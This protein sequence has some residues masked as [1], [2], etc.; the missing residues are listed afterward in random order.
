MSQSLKRGML[1][2]LSAN[3]LGLIINVITNF[4]LPKYLAVESY[5]AIKT[6]TLYI[7][8]SGFFHLGYEDGMYLKY[9]GKSKYELDKMDFGLN[10]SSLRIFQLV[11]SLIIFIIAMILNN[12]ILLVFSISLLPYN[13]VMYFRN[14]YQAIGEFNS[15][16]KLMNFMTC[17][18]FVINMFFLFVLKNNN[19]IYYILSNA[20]VYICVWIFLEVKIRYKSK[21]KSSFFLF[22]ITEFLNNVSSGI[23]L[24]L[25]TFSSILL[26][27][28]D[29]WFVQYFLGTIEF[30]MYSFAVSMESFLNVAIT[31]VTLTLYNYFCKGIEREDIDKMRKYLL[32]FGSLLVGCGF[33]LKF[34]VE[35]WLVHYVS[36]LNVLFILFSSQIFYVIIKAIYVNLY[37]ACKKQ[38]RYFKKLIVVIFFAFISNYIFYCIWNIKESFAIAT[39]LSALLWLILC[40]VDFPQYKMCFKEFFYS[41]VEVFAFILLGVFC[42]VFIGA[43]LYLILS[44]ILIIILF[45]K[46]A[47]SI[48]QIII[49]SNNCGH[50]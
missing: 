23:L 34:I 45:K 14:L 2:I 1:Y 32:M 13:M 25:G 8:Y 46:E 39:L 3:I 50:D 31:P 44:I 42:N 16:S 33:P 41:V 6:Y 18:I 12:K 17:S 20:I 28:M 35:K 11:V 38:R 7:S 9:G 5:A 24:M 26:T 4:A 22:S 43:V 21:I 37:K 15:Y 10:I 27:S 19:Y 47:S 48:F 49:H 36:S 30:A 40:Q 29:R